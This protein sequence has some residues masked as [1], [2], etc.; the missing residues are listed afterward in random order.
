MFSSNRTR[1]QEGSFSKH[2]ASKSKS[3]KKNPSF[4]DS[5]RRVERLA[6][7]AQ[8]S[9]PQSNQTSPTL[10]SAIIT[11]SVGREQ[12][13]F[14]AHEDV[15]SHSPW[16]QTLCSGQFFQSTN[17]RIDLPDEEPEVFSSILEYLYKGDYYPRMEYD[18]KRNSWNL[19]DGGNANNAHEAIVQSSV[20][21]ILKDTVI[22]C[23]ADKY[24]LQELKK[25][26]L[27]KQGLQSGIQCST[28]LTS[29]RYAYANTPD[30]DSKLR[31]HYLALI[32]RARHT[33]KRSGTMQNEMENGG[34]LFFDLF[35]AMVNHM[36]DLSA[37]SPH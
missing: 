18:K 23:Q 24:G 33:F 20:G 19:E 2:R 29:A 22:Y 26:A 31:A 3:H 1:H 6:Q 17:K 30:N 37:K 36:D 13:L 4:R 5:P 15:L 12:R 14:A 10:G 21:P 34:K 11:I 32:I 8:A 16:F 28:I 7:H 27:K 35:V 9:S 25:L